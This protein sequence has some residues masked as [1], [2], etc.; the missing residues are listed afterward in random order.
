MTFAQRGLTATEPHE[1][2]SAPPLS[3]NGMNRGNIEYFARYWKTRLLV[4]CV[5]CFVFVSLCFVYSR[6]CFF[7]IFF[8]RFCFVVI[9]SIQRRGT[10]SIIVVYTYIKEFITISFF[11]QIIEKMCAKE[12]I[13]WWEVYK[14]GV[15][16]F[17]CKDI[18]VN[19]FFFTKLIIYL[20]KGN[21][22]E[23]W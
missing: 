10:P 9:P 23:K 19:E 7:Y 11:F 8:Y 1:Y 13:F 4:L 5:F 17:L 21:I 18:I 12:F 20:K 6:N 15:G 14:Q 16:F 3:C 22:L 2:C